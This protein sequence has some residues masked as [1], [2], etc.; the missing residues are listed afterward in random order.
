MGII[1]HTLYHLTYPTSTQHTNCTGSDLLNV[2]ISIS[3]RLLWYSLN[4]TYNLLFAVCPVTQSSW[5]RYR[6]SHNYTDD[7]NSVKIYVTYQWALQFICLCLWTPFLFYKNLHVKWV[8]INKNTTGYTYTH[9]HT[10]KKKKN[11]TRTTILQSI[12]HKHQKLHTKG[13]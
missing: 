1:S 11:T 2:E 5:K 4:N 6:V 12:S 10:Y 9:T 7:H 8:Q 13:H 3:C